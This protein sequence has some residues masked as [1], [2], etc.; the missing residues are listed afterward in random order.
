MNR[1]PQPGQTHQGK[2]AE[3]ALRLGG[4]TE[5]EVR[6]VGAVEAAEEQVEHLFAPRYQTAASPVHRAVWERAVPL[7]LFQPPDLDRPDP[8]D[9][10]IE[11]CVAVTRRR[12]ESGTLYDEKGKI[13]QETLQELAQHGYWGMIIPRA[14]GG[15]EAP[16]PKFVHLLT[17][18][19]C[20][21][22]MV[23]GLASVHQ[24]IGAVDPILTFGTEEQ[25]RRFLPLLASGEKLSGFALTEPP[26]GSDLTAL[27]TRAE[28][29]PGGFKLYG[30]KLFITNAL[31]GTLL[32]VVALLDGRPQ[33]FIAELPNEEG[34]TF[35]LV[36][37]G[38][39]AL[40]RVYNHGIRFQGFFV[41]EE[42]LLRPPSGD[43][44]TIAYHGLN[45]GRV[46]LC[47]TAAGVMRTM[48]ANMLP[49]VDYRRTYGAKIKTRELVKWRI[50]R[51]AALLAG[52]EA[53][54]QWGAHLLQL[55]YR[56]E[57][58]CTV[59]KI[60]GSE[61]QKEAA[62]ELL[63]K[64]HGGRSFLVGHPFGDNVHDFLA[65]LIYEGEGQMLTLAFFK[66]LVKQH[67]LEFFEPIGRKL[68]QLGVP[69][70]NPAN[71]R[72][73]WA[74]RQEF[75]R[76]LRWWLEQLMVWSK[77]TAPS[78][79]PPELSRH[80]DFALAQFRRY[81]LELSGLMRRY[82]LKLV[83]RQ[84][85]IVEMSLRIQK[86]VALLVSCLWAA[87]QADPVWVAAADVLGQDLRRELTGE[88]PTARYYRDC[89]RLADRILDG[90]F[91]AIE[92]CPRYEILMPYENP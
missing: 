65:P 51:M 26:A 32:C 37:Y 90:E 22:A 8:C 11:Q 80:V 24:C 63:M 60:F 86:T 81:P 41:P 52:A 68:Q 77:G 83:D 4:K 16:L 2:F 15:Q 21:E 45:R 25:K 3:T 50:A 17:R 13:S 9:D 62:I 92:E 44:L 20:Y 76:Y 79:L 66:T 87:K 58:E 56:G 46:S 64:T 39:H 36:R 19:A 35:Q 49:W 55:G 42:N 14:Y 6:R 33:V 48:L 12:F 10:A 38:L 61:A 1:E 54:S 82:Q 71:P 40:R 89:R 47:A 28:R 23:G 59:A 88:R 72:H 34:P 69:T 53:L 91:R 75:G 67:G 30:E 5:E 43:G 57:L 27:R 78:G 85:A 70:L 18:C 7:E 31:P 74:L 84:C 29:V 73:L